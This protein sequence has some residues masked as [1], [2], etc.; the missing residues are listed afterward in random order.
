MRERLAWIRPP[1]YLIR[2]TQGRLAKISTGH[3]KHI[4]GIDAQ[5]QVGLGFSFPLFDWLI[6][7]AHVSLRSEGRSDSPGEEVVT[8]TLP[9]LTCTHT[10]AHAQSF[11]SGHISLTVVK[12]RDAC[13][14]IT[15]ILRHQYKASQRTGWGFCRVVSSLVWPP[16]SDRRLNRWWCVSGTRCV[17]QCCARGAMAAGNTIRRRGVRLSFIFP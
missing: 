12:L 14:T 6:S 9:T 1:L 17:A 10:H 2:L 13:G 16:S 4:W 11:S 8:H 15:C 7:L 5:N 3:A